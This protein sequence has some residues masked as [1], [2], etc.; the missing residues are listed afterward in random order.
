MGNCIKINTELT[1]IIIRISIILIY[2]ITHLIM[3]T[4]SLIGKFAWVFWLLYITVIAPIFIFIHLNV[5]SVLNESEKAKI[6]LVAQTLKFEQQEMLT[7]SMRTFFQ[8]PNIIDVSLVA[9]NNSILFKQHYPHSKTQEAITFSEPVVD[10]FTHRIQAT[11]LISYSN[12]FVRDLQ[13][14]LFIQLIFLSLFALLIF[15]ITY[16]YFQKLF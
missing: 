7:D 15:S 13:T 11:L 16:W 10:P 8:N 3:M 4:H 1:N 12:N 9:K 2:V 14:K 6:K 5:S